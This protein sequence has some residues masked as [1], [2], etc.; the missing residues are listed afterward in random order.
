MKQR[1]PKHCR[2]C[3]YFHRAGHKEGSALHGSK[4][5]NWCSKYSTI[6]NKAVSI[7]LQQNGKETQPFYQINL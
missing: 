3:V 2:S 5:D 1:K 7:C 4:Y 6:A